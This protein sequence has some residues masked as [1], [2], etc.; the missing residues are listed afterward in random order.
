V[1]PAA[2]ATSGAPPGCVD[3]L[4]I[5]S[6]QDVPN[7]CSRECCICM[8]GFTHQDV[9]VET[10][11]RHLFH[12][13]CC[14]EWL[15]QARTCPVCRDDIPSTLEMVSNSNGGAGRVNH[16]N[17]E[18]NDTRRSDSSNGQSTS[19]PIGPSGRPI[20][21]LLH[22]FRVTRNHFNDNSRS[23]R[24]LDHTSSPVVNST[25]RQNNSNATISDSMIDLEVER[26]SSAVT[27]Y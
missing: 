9:I 24:H 3:K 14:R 22:V 27:R 17:N 23:S 25:T 4:T 16:E 8:E 18:D 6:T 12:K 19:I 15:R 7:L 2:Y 20:A 13:N 11:C 21:G 1:I 26:R 5:R 10:N